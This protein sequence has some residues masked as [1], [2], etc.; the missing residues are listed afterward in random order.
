MPHHSITGALNKNDLLV[1]F[2]VSQAV[3]ELEIKKR[4]ITIE[5]LLV[6]S[7][8]SFGKVDISS[9]N[10]DQTLSDPDGPFNLAVAITDEGEREGQGG[11][12]IVAASSFFLYP[13]EVL[14]VRLTQPGNYDFLFN[15]LNWLQGKEELISIS[16][17][18]LIV[19]NLR[20]NQL[21]FFLYAGITVILIPLLI[22]GSGLVMWLRRRH[23]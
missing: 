3:E 8:K 12:A 17:K 14:P 18:N 7:E 20:L 16:A 1:L 9:D 5:P 23:L 15:S 10:K 11:K 2:P 6:S 22:L 13:E 21:Q 19:F 4:S